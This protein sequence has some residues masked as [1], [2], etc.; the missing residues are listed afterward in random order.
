MIKLNNMEKKTINK[1]VVFG[2]WIAAGILLMG[3]IHDV[4]TFTPLILDNLH[5]LSED[6]V[7]VFICFS[8]G[9]GM[10]LILCGILLFPLLNQLE[11]FPFVITPLFVIS[12]FLLI[13]GMLSVYFM[14]DNP[15]AWVVSALCIIMFGI[16]LK[17]KARINET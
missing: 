1:W 7:K 15:F 4:A 14:P 17:L 8:L 9:T 3:I 16:I 6:A 5:S 2:K 10:S 13:Y 12:L 11:R